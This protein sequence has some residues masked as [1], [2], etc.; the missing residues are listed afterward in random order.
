MTSKYIRYGKTF[1]MNN[2]DY[3]SL[4][5]VGKNLAR[6]SDLYIPLFVMGFGRCR[7]SGINIQKGNVIKS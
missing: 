1:E 3:A 4:M 2:K 7:L 6:P 5:Q